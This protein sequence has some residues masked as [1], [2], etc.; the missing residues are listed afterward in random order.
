MQRRQSPKQTQLLWG[1]G[2]AGGIGAG[3]LAPALHDGLYDAVFRLLYGTPDHVVHPLE[4][5]MPILLVGF[6]TT[7]VGVVVYA[8]GSRIP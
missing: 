5:D 7:I 1:G 3:F 2:V 6:L 4:Q 8:V